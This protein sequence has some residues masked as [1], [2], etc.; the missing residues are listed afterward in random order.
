M[1]VPPASSRLAAHLAGVS[2][3][4]RHSLA[5]IVWAARRDPLLTGLSLGA[6]VANGALAGLPLLLL[7][8]GT[9]AAA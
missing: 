9:T 1:S 3:V 6:T 4:V 8:L 7:T 2:G 5:A